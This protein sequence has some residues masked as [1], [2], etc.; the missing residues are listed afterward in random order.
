MA[1]PQLSPTDSTT[2]Q[3]SQLFPI[4]VNTDDTLPNSPILSPTS[5]TSVKSASDISINLA[6][7]EQIW[8]GC[9]PV[10]FDMATNEVINKKDPVSIFLLLPRISYLPLVTE[11]VHNHFATYAPAL[12]DGMWFEFNG[13]LL[14]CNFP[15]GVLYDLYIHEQYKN[16]NENNNNHDNN[17][18]KID[19]N[20]DP[21]WKIIVH[22]Q[23]YPSEDVIM[24]CDNINVVKILFFNYL[25]QSVFLAYNNINAIASL[26]KDDQNALWNGV[27]KADYNLYF[28]IYQSISNKHSKMMRYPFRIIL[29]GF[30]E[31]HN[32]Q[33]KIDLIPIQRPIKVN[34][35]ENDKDGNIITLEKCL[36]DII[37]GVMQMY[38]NQNNNYNNNKQID[39]I[40]Q[41]MKIPLDVPMMWLIRHATSADCF[42][43]IVIVNHLKTGRCMQQ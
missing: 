26:K 30:D 32:T 9:V 29:R 23:S 38:Y 41:G 28:P 8:N 18:G 24:R 39:I 17:D 20:D 2:T 3:N 27:C 15:I 1:S 19:Q 34:N 11:K 12:S 42:L 35:D 7:R 33:K 14:K 37:P 16:P 13:N 25:K 22:F 21:V 36:K 40:I 5:T 4:T 10:L 6:L 31:E 43:Y